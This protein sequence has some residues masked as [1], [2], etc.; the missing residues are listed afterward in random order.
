MYARLTTFRGTSRFDEAVSHVRDTIL[1]ELRQQKGFSSASLVCDRS[2][3][4]LKALILWETEADR[5]SSEGFAEK[6]RKQTLDL[7]GGEVSVERF[8]QVLSEVGP[9]P[10]VPGSKLHLRPLKMDPAK[11]DENLAFFEQTVVPDIKATPGF[12]SVRSFI[13]RQSGEGQVGTVWADQAS[14]ETAR[15][16]ADERRSVASARG[17]EIGQD[18]VLEILFRSE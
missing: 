11:V 17:V 18:Q 8:E 2:A 5:D 7:L 16:K 4:I 10:P 6:T 3:G 12:Q 14:L 15:K 9:T 1:P 13:N